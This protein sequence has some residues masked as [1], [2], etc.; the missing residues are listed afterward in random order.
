MKPCAGVPLVVISPFADRMSVV[1]DTF[2]RDT[3]ID[4][5]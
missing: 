1:R 2:M 5:R 3:F 4:A